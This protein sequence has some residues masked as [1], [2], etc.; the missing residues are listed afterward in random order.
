MSLRIASELTIKRIREVGEREELISEILL[1][2]S[3]TGKLISGAILEGAVQW[4]NR[5][6]L[7][8]TDDVAYEEAF[9]IYLLDDHL[10]IL[11]SA[12]IGA[13]RMWGRVCRI[14]PPRKVGPL[15]VKTSFGERT[16]E[17]IP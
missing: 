11:G 2:G 17:R 9:G 3:S 7:F 5:Y 1:N 6:L 10:N 4:E 12:L 14:L 8:M 16:T 13:C 15:W